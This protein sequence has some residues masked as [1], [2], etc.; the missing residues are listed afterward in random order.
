M[1]TEMECSIGHLGT[2]VIGEMGNLSI[3]DSIGEGLKES[4]IALWNT[5]EPFVSSDEFDGIETGE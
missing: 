4:A 1:T 3:G 5:Q 2:L